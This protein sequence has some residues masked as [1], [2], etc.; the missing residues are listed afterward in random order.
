MSHV[1]DNGQ[2][3][4]HG[5]ACYTLVEFVDLGFELHARRVSLQIRICNV[6]LLDPAELVGHILNAKSDKS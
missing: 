3:P 6:F 5:L 4:D 2:V 1:D